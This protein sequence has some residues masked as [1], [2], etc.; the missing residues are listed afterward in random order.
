VNP[1]GH[2]ND[3]LGVILAE[4]RDQRSLLQRGGWTTQAKQQIERKIA[5]LEE[6]KTEILSRRGNVE[7]KL[8]PLH[9][10]YSQALDFLKSKGINA[11]GSTVVAIAS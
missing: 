2:I 10:L 5:E 7:A 1:P 3:E 4:H 8:E 9:H 11:Q 6:K